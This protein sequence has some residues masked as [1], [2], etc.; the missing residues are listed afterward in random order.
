MFAILASGSLNELFDRLGARAASLLELPSSHPSTPWFPWLDFSKPAPPELC[1]ANTLTLI[2]A[3]APG[4]SHARESGRGLSKSTEEG[5]PRGNTLPLCEM[6]TMC[7]NDPVR[8]QLP[9]RGSRGIRGGGPRNTSSSGIKLRG[10]LQFAEL[11]R[12]PRVEEPKALFSTAQG[13][14]DFKALPVGEQLAVAISFRKVSQGPLALADGRHYETAFVSAGTLEKGV[15]GRGQDE[16]GTARKG[17]P[18]RR[19]L[20]RA[21]PRLVSAILWENRRVKIK[22]RSPGLGG[23]NGRARGAER[24]R[25][26]RSFTSLLGPKPK[27]HVLVVVTAGLGAGRLV[28]D[29]RREELQPLEVVH[30]QP[31]Q[32]ASDNVRS[33]PNHP[34]QARSIIPAKQRVRAGMCLRLGWGEGTEAREELGREEAVAAAARTHAAHRNSH[35][36]IAASLLPNG[37]RAELPSTFKVAQWRSGEPGRPLPECWPAAGLLAPQ[38]RVLRALFLPIPN[39]L[40]PYPRRG[41]ESPPLGASAAPARP[42]GRLS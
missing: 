16:G 28:S 22:P 19:G 35:C 32:P 26:V 12:R 4:S 9:A 6:R 37:P 5:K 24:K 15:G 14:G 17:E 27:Q 39:P 2:R 38:S 29:P 10:T 18:G 40:R 33:T 34:R 3:R 7:G 13:L 1:S 11:R 20:E 42:A 36:N 23:E 25:S 41:E 31:V 8:V 21:F 30:Q